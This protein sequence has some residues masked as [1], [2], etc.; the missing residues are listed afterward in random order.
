[1][2]RAGPSAPPLLNAKDRGVV[3]SAAIDT[4]LLREITDE[5]ISYMIERIPMGRIGQAQEV[6]APAHLLARTRGVLFLY[7]A[8]FDIS[9]GRG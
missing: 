8:S 9:G 5:H 6:A 3:A 4:P 1:M 2:G 7:R